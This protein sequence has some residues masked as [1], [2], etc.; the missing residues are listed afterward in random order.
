MASALTRTP[1]L[2]LEVD[3]R[4][5]QRERDFAMSPSKETRNALRVAYKRSG[6]REA[7]R[8]MAL[9][10]ARENY[11]SH[12]RQAK[13]HPKFEPH[14]YN[15]ATA[16]GHRQ[17]PDLTKTLRRA[18]DSLRRYV[19]LAHRHGIDPK[20]GLKQGA[21]SFDEHMAHIKHVSHAEAHNHI[22]RETDQADRDQVLPENG[23]PIRHPHTGKVVGHWHS[24]YPGE[25]DE[26]PSVPAADYHPHGQSYGTKKQQS[27]HLHVSGHVSVEGRK[28]H[29]NEI[30]DVIHRDY[31]ERPQV[32]HGQRGSSIYVD[33]PE[34]QGVTGVVSRSRIPTRVL[35][36]KEKAEVEQKREKAASLPEDQPHPEL[37][38]LHAQ[39]RD[40]HA[41]ATAAEKKKNNRGLRDQWLSGNTG[42]KDKARAA[43]E[44]AS[45]D[46][47]D[48]VSAV[49][50][51][52]K[53]L[54]LHP[55][56][57]FTPKSDIKHGTGAETRHFR[58]ML[59]DLHGATRTPRWH[60]NSSP[61]FHD[62]EDAKRYEL[63]LHR[64]VGGRV[65]TYPREDYAD[66]SKTVH[67]VDWSPL[68]KK[69]KAELQ[70]EWTRTELCVRYIVEADMDL[71][72]RRRRAAQGGPDEEAAHFV[73][74]RRVGRAHEIF[75][76]HIEKIAR[77]ERKEKQALAHH[78][79]VRRGY[80]TGDEEET[81]ALVDAASKVH[82]AAV[83]DLA[84]TAHRL[85][86]PA[87]QYIDVDESE[88]G[89]VH[90][91]LRRLAD[92][93]HPTGRAPA[94]HWLSSLH[95]PTIHRMELPDRDS[96]H[97]EP[98]KKHLFHALKHHGYA[99]KVSD[100]GDYIDITGTD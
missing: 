27:P 40:Y 36:K 4:L 54:G 61:R 45:A 12:M 95:G 53:E 3:Q 31:G 39:M 87:G 1:I 42:P 6:D 85:D 97:F 10:R 22:V 72:Q 55:A 28:N 7:M 76:P 38:K 86:H 78:W 90:L 69:Q 67:N 100:S 5:R 9:D 63:A 83:V 47:H 15:Y 84:R 30:A 46:Y 99:Y 26:H 64:H 73:A 59:A 16:V 44:K 94:N 98:Y 57:G 65:S 56:H 29:A 8:D 93:S 92:A 51:K 91:H 41:K 74:L 35:R 58:S 75:K 37:A 48:A 81:G 25:I 14:H 11:Q 89:K 23:T 77:A 33:R 43:Y 2:C 32:T 34:D 50:E 62:E 49:H 17:H 52:A 79:D 13:D 71:A 21:R 70:K 82:R 24:H 96:P 19:N 20:H 88:P 60:S 68:T 66:T 18:N 80:K